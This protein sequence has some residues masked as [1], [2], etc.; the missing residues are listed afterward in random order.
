M[1]ASH[2]DGRAYGF[3]STEYILEKMMPWIVEQ[4]KKMLILL[5][6]SQGSVMRTIKGNGR[7]DDV[8]IEYLERN[9]IPCVDGLQKHVDDYQDFKITPEEYMDRCY[10]KAAAAAVFG[11]YSP[12][13]NHFYAISIKNEILDWLDPKPPAYRD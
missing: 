6:Y 10:I 12:T 13:G 5:S 4:G 7:F 2:V 3:K 1:G 11:H 9:K 8:F